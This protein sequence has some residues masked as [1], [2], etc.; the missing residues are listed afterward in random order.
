MSIVS[1]NACISLSKIDINRVRVPPFK[2]L[3]RSFTVDVG[4]PPMVQ[5]WHGGFIEYFI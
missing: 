3:S 4:T 2:I 1:Y 5:K